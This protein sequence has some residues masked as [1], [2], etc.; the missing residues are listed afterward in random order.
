MVAI[1]LS[2][3]QVLHP[4]SPFMP[5]GGFAIFCRVL[6]ITAVGDVSYVSDPPI[7]SLMP[8]SR[9]RFV[10]NNENG[11]Q[12]LRLIESSRARCYLLRCD[13]LRTS[14]AGGCRST[15]GVSRT[16]GISVSGHT[17]K[18]PGAD[19]SPEKGVGAFCGGGWSCSLRL[20][21][22]PW[23]TGER[24]AWQKAPSSRA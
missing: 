17:G 4:L 11:F 19:R 9:A 3:A 6:P 20:P 15:R 21:R 23:E 24:N 2:V 18:L 12:P 14:G 22:N 1:S 7:V 8:F 10:E 16:R 5:S 13:L